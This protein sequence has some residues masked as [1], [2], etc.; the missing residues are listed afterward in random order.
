VTTAAAPSK[1]AREMISL[2]REVGFQVKRIAAHGTLMTLGEHTISV[3]HTPSDHRSYTALLADIRRAVPDAEA[4]R[5]VKADEDTRRLRRERN[6]RRRSNGNGNGPTVPNW[7]LEDRDGD[8]IEP[9]QAPYTGCADC[10][11]R[12][13]SDLSP[14]GRLCPQCDGP[15]VKEGTLVPT[16]AAAPSQERQ[17]PP[18]RPLLPPPPPRIRSERYQPSS[19]PSL[20]TPKPAPAPAGSSNGRK[21]PL[22]PDVLDDFEFKTGRPDVYREFM[23]GRIYRFT[24]D[25][26]DGTAPRRFAAILRES[27]RKRGKKARTR[28]GEDH[29]VFQAYDP[30]QAA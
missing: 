23:D 22:M 1:E 10:G 26:L 6:R 12:W 5:R 20:V 29:V 17:R 2:A 11:Y 28:V 19:E 27:A 18:E 21:K 8:D 4:L 16:W 24:S 25:D 30:E 15:I 13:Q 3:A 9:V 7:A 14:E